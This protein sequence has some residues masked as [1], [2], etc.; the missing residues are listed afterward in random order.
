MVGFL[1]NPLGVHARKVSF[2]N[3]ELKVY[4][5]HE[6]VLHLSNLTS[7]PTVKKRFFSS[8]LTINVD[9]GTDY[10]L[11]GVRHDEAQSFISVIKIAWTNYNRKI[12]QAE[13]STIE[14]LITVIAELENPVQYPAACKL[15]P[16]LKMARELNNKLFSKLSKDAIGQNANANIKTIQSFIRN[17]RVVREEALAKF[18]QRHLNEWSKFFDTFEDNPLTL[19]QRKAIITDEDTTLV[20]AGAGSGKTSVITAKAGY[21]LKSGIRKPEEIL[22]LSFARDAASEMTDRIK[23]K[24]REHLE[25]WTFHALAYNIIGAVEGSKPAL[26]AHATDERAYRSLIQNILRDLVRSDR[27]VSKS[28]IKW[29]SYDCLEEKS[30]W[31][32][33]TKHDYYTFLEKADLRT[34]QGE[35]V[36]SFEELMIANWLFENGVEYEYEPLYEHKVSKGGYK[37]YCPD[38]RLK[39]SDVY[40]EHFGVRRRKM[41]DGTFQFTTAPYVNREN[42]LKS[43]EWKRHVHEQHGTTLIETFSYERQEG[44]LL[45]M[46]AKKI[47]PYEER[48]PRSREILFDRIIELNQTDN[49]V[50]LISTFLR[51]Y[52]GGGYQINECTEKAERLRFGKRAKAF[53]A[54]FKLVYVE[55]KRQMGGRIDFEDMILRAAVYIESG[56][57]ISPFKHILVDEFQDISRSRGRLIQALKAQHSEARVFA[58][59]DDWQSIYRFAGS[60]IHL[61]RNFEEEFGGVFDGE[62]GIHKTIDLGRTFRS[63]DQIAEIAKR[64]ILKNPAQL[65]KTIIPAGIADTPALKVAPIFRHDANQKLAEVLQSLPVNRNESKRT[66]VLLLGRYR[67]LAPNGL[68]QLQ[69]QLPH[70]DITFKTIHASKGLEADHVI[71]L[72]M[73]RGRTGFPSEIVDDELLSLVSPDTELFENAEERRVMY[74]ALTRARKTVTLMSLLSKQSVFVTELLEDSEYNVICD[75]EN[76]LEYHSCGECGGNLL[77]FPTKNGRTWYRCEHTKLCGYS[78]TACSACGTGL[79]VNQDKSKIKKCNY[80]G[81]EYPK[82]PECKSG[83]LVERKSRFGLFW[84]CVNFPRCQ[85]KMKQSRES[86]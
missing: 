82:C 66:T 69:R 28:I 11:K 56:Q 13:R 38:F 86:V 59:G 44:C 85:G 53:L 75:S 57:Y 45:E 81:A 3:E 4:T 25:A 63:V 15:S 50:Q 49:F 80:C 26:V 9:D 67:H 22:L 42:Y 70:L 55:Y 7:A 62:I 78:L 16:T 65:N 6:N 74:V 29:F 43:M 58:V 46:L 21:L 47:A 41:A 61:M 27:K 77:A 83:W 52:K 40:I 24:C 48:A 17:A 60:D 14:K 23:E 64:F 34:F 8:T 32:F 68:Y 30:A 84:G 5:R 36:K 37:D 79:P 2:R 39:K 51:H 76:Y 71:I 18:E 73:F 12:F 72:S 33:K 19:E 10:R 20:L 31:D 54:I 35:E 1:L